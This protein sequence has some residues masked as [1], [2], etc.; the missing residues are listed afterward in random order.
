MDI[1]N[2]QKS[3]KLDTDITVT[4]VGLGGI[5]FW[6]AKLL[7]MSGVNKFYFFDDD[8]IEDTN[9]NRLDL[10]YT[11]IGLNKAG[12]AKK[13]INQIRPECIIYTFPYKFKETLYTS[14]DFIVDCTDNLKSQL[15]I[16]EIAD[17]NGSIYIKAGYDGTHISINN[18]VG[19]WGEAPDGYTITP[20]WV[21]PAILVAT[22][23]VAKMLKSYTNEL[24]LDILDIFNY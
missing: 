5:G 6:V 18:R 24:S 4:I 12:V 22:L 16:Q 8:V 13:I 15:E 10:P 14:S 2:R 19:E 1:Y 7:A 20:S 9:L 11:T 17:I 23:T 3:F 21:V